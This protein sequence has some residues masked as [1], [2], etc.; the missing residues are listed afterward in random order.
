MHTI[1]QTLTHT[2]QGWLQGFKLVL[3]ADVCYSLNMT[4]F[5]F[6]AAARLLERSLDA[7]FLLGYVSRYGRL[8][9]VRMTHHKLLCAHNKEAMQVRRHGV[10]YQ[11]SDQGAWLQH[12]KGS[13]RPG[14]RRWSTGLHLQADMA[15]SRQFVAVRS[16]AGLGAGMLNRWEVDED[17][18]GGN[19]GEAGGER[20][21][22]A[23]R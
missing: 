23:A 7:I 19:E 20:E 3:G 6:A 17:E 9:V 15:S 18:G 5:M 14:C 22:I 12:A 2:Q 1:C 21:S 10:L 4:P 11:W 13:A 8:P 16:R